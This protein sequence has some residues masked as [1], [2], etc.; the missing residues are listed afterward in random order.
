MIPWLAFSGACAKSNLLVPSR[1]HRIG[2]QTQS[3]SQSTTRVVACEYRYIVASPCELRRV[4]WA[5]FTRCPVC[6]VI[7]DCVLVRDRM[8]EQIRQLAARGINLL[9]LKSHK[10]TAAVGFHRKAGPAREAGASCLRPQ[11]WV[12]VAW[13]T[14]WSC[15]RVAGRWCGCSRSSRAQTKQRTL[16]STS[17]YSH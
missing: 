9:A 16:A 2:W 12:G 5:F 17:W 11:A 7:V 10:S 3:C 4:V 6:V 14:G 1:R 8:Y 15:P 13:D